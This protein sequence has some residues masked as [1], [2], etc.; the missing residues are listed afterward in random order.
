MQKAVMNRRKF[1][2]TT[3]LLTGAAVISACDLDKGRKSSYPSEG[4][5][6]LVGEE[7]GCYE[8]EEDEE[9]VFKTNNT[10]I[11]LVIIER[12]NT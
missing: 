12:W 2:A 1:V 7:V 10:K 8:G 3:S 9:E 6:V 5:E 11:D 4:I